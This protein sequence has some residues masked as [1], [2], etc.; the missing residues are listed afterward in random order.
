M[1]AADDT[2]AEDHEL[3]AMLR[4]SIERYT[5]EHYNFER[6]WAAL[7]DPRA[8]SEQAWTDYARF[9]WLAL[10]LPPESGGVAAGFRATAPWME[11]VGARLLLEPIL[12]SAIMSTGLV[13]R[14]ASAAQQAQL[15]PGLA[16]GTLKLAFAHQETLNAFS[17]Q[18][19]G[20]DFA[21]GAIRGAK[22][23]V[24]HGDCAERLIVSAVNRE[25]GGTVSLFI[26]NPLAPGLRRQCYR[27]LDGRGAANLSFDRVEA[28]PLKAPGPSDADQQ[29]I[30]AALEE[31]TVALCSEALGAIRALNMATRGYLQTRK[32]FGRPIGA[33]QALQHRMVEMHLLEQE[34]RALTLAALCA[35]S[36][37]AADRARI[38]SAARAFVCS[39]ARRI[40]A[41]AVQMH[42]GIGI[43]DELDISHYYRRLMVLGTLDGNRE[44]HFARF[45]AACQAIGH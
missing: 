8:Y 16:D 41:E 17:E 27:L 40:A 21:G 20:C 10:R 39:A 43:T 9:G 12:A 7:N 37:P 6:R 33:N 1:T 2:E 24:L 42:G 18:A 4:Q 23:A 35:A 45:A 3:I 34:V 36:E 29:A 28:E 30:A 22:I 14:R 25:R 5:A 31:A 26:V 32:Q 15:L 13:L 19:I 38:I 44:Y 11:A